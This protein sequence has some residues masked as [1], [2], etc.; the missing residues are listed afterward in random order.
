MQLFSTIPINVKGATIMSKNILVI[1]G[2]PRKGGNSETLAKAFAKGAEA[3][4]HIVTMFNA[5]KNIGGC[6]ACDTCWSKGRA[7]SFSDGFT[8]LEPLLE[9]ADAVVFATPLYWFSFSAQIKASIDRIYA[10]VSPNKLRSLKIKE[11]ALLACAGD[12]DVHV[13][14][15]LI[16]TYEIMMRYINWHNAGVLAVPGVMEKGDILQTDAL[17]KAEQF[18]MNF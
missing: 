13:F 10:Y 14:D 4:G 2:S 18:G 16:L 9:Q 7:C 15:G 1:T 12:T 11:S 3:K 5:S 6:K 17:E 8:E